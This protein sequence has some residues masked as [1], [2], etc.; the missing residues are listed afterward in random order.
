MT[1]GYVWLALCVSK[2]VVI[3]TASTP[4]YII[5]QAG[6]TRTLLQVRTQCF[7]IA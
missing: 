4:Y 6:D 1:D 7:R 2:I 3:T 5:A